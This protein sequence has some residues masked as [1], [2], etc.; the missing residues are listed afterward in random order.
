M[1]ALL[2]TALAVLSIGLPV[3]QHIGSVDLTHGPEPSR[4]LEMQERPYSWSDPCKKDF[5]E[6]EG[7]GW[8]PP[9]EKVSRDIVVEMVGMRTT[10]RSLSTT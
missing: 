7:H 6:L 2:G 8:L 9:E 3:A 5:S 4:P 1:K 10:P